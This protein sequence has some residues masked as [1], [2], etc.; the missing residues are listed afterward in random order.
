MSSV[1]TEVFK[2][3]PTRFTMYGSALPND[4]ALTDLKVSKVLTKRLHRFAKEV[5]IAS[6]FGPLL[7]TC[8]VTVSTMD[9][10]RLV[11]DRAYTVKFETPQGGKICVVGI[12]IKDGKPV[13][14]H[15]FEIQD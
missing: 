9:A 10:D 12:F 5:M 7:D 1:Q 14:H 11:N 4:L 3:L 6:G 2:Q 15:G 13:L 8:T